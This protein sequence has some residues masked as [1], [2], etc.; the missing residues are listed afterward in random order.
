MGLGSTATSEANG[1]SCV[2]GVSCMFSSVGTS[3][4][5]VVASS[6][7]LFCGVGSVS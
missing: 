1:L 7:F 6:F 3:V 5:G 2:W 4:I